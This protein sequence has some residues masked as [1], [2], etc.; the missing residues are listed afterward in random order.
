MV[1]LHMW[2]DGYSDLEFAPDT[3]IFGQPRRGAASKFSKCALIPQQQQ[4]RT[5]AREATPKETADNKLRRTV[6]RNQSSRRTDVPAR[7]SVAFYKLV[8]RRAKPE[9]RGPT[10]VLDTDETGVAAK[11]KG[12]TSKVARYCVRQRAGVKDA[13]DADWNLM[14]LGVMMRA[15]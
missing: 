10:V 2:R 7:G 3:S 15:L 14:R 9:W 1:S 8:D 12:Q 4:V 6:E 5:T 11:L 13:G